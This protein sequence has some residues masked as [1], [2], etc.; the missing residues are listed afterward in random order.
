MHSQGYNKNSTKPTQLG[1]SGCR[2]KHS[3]IWVSQTTQ[4]SHLTVGYQRLNIVKPTYGFIRLYTVKPSHCWVYQANWPSYHSQLGLSDY[5]AK[6]YSPSQ[7][8]QDTTKPTYGFIT[9]L[10]KPTFSL[11]LSGFQGNGQ[12]E[13]LS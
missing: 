9:L 6:G 2:V 13:L 4:P 8:Q 7:T 12:E 10:A 11:G 3:H 1:L 5:P